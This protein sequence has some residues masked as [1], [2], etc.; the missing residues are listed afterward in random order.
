MFRALSFSFPRA[1][2]WN[3]YC[4]RTLNFFARHGLLGDLDTSY[5]IRLLSPVGVGTKPDHELNEFYRI[6]LRSSGTLNLPGRMQL[7]LLSLVGSMSLTHIYPMSVT[8][9]SATSVHNPLV[10]HYFGP[11]SLSYSCLYAVSGLLTSYSSLEGLH[12]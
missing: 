6:R 11:H 5:R 2:R 12:K 7:E 9:L 8:V 4:S 1:V 10:L 3:D